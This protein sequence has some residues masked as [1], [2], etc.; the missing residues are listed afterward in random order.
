[1]HIIMHAGEDWLATLTGG[2]QCCLRT[3]R[4]GEAITSTT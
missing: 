2:S 4:N 3:T 1:M